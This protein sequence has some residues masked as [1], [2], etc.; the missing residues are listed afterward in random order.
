MKDGGYAVKKREKA[1]DLLK[2]NA[3]TQY[4][5]PQICVPQQ[6]FISLRLKINRNDI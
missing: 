3:G 5:G 4:C 2:K 6:I 1:R